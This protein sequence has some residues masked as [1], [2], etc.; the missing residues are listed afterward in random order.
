MTSNSPR[1]GNLLMASL[2]NLILLMS[3]SYVGLFAV[4]LTRKAGFCLIVFVLVILSAWNTFPSNI[5]M[6]PSLSLGHDFNFSFQ[7][8]LSEMAPNPCFMLF[9]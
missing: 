1:C 8:T 5:F 2:N 4:Y 9:I 3:S 6:A 7:T